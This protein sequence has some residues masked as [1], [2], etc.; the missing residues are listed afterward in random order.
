MQDSDLDLTGVHWEKR[1]YHD[2]WE[3]LSHYRRRGRTLVVG[4]D[5]H[6]GSGKTT[7]A[8]GLAAQ[9]RGI[10]L[11]HTDDLAWHHS[12]FDWGQQLIDHLLAP[13]RRG[14]ATIFYRPPAWIARGRPGAISVPADAAAVL[15]E[16]VGSCRREVRSFLDA[17]V[18]VHARPD[19]ARRRVIAKGIGTEEL[20]DDWMTQENAFL[21]EQRPWESADLL[22]AGELGQPSRDGSYGN[23]VT[24]AGP[25]GG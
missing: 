15:V 4:V 20:I 25:G 24:A 1:T 9:D 5:G 3:E 18:W 8:L 17:T 22:V 21:A 23:V 12:F 7:L 19:V 14:D 13:L 6:S 2:V 10:A 11:V 16:G